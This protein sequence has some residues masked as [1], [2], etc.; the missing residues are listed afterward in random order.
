VQDNPQ[1]WRVGIAGTVQTMTD[2]GAGL[3]DVLRFGEGAAEGGWKGYGKD[4]LRLLMLLGP[5]GRIAG[6]ANRFL[7]PLI[8]AGNLRLAVQ[9][10]GVTGPCTFQAVNNALSIAKGKNLFVTVQD[11]AGALGKT[12]S[13][14]KRVA[15]NPIEYDLAAWADELVPVIRQAGI[16]VKEVG[17]LRSVDEV[18]KVAKTEAGPVVFAIRTTVRMKASGGVTAI[19]EFLHSVIAMRSPTG[20]VRFADYGGK[21]YGS[22]PE[23]IAKWGTP[24]SE[25]KLFQSGSSATV[26]E[27]IRLTGELARKIGN[28]ATLVMEGLA[29]IE[30][31][32][33]GVE[34]A[35]P[36][37]AVA[38]NAPTLDD[39]AEP[40]VVK[41]SFDAYKARAKGRPVVRL[42]EI[43]IK[44]G[45]RRAPRSDW[46]TGV[47]YRL[48]ALGFGAGPVDGIMGPRTRKAVMDFQ[49]AYP[50]LAVD[51]I[52]GGHTQARLCEVCGY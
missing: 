23:L 12:L 50:P 44:A 20:A 40:E 30:T 3:V 28:G 16:R 4:A 49:R 1:W 33:N 19:E 25:I 15:S 8:K 17:G 22:L 9:V 31:S 43:V 14:L 26:I 24:V 13:Q 34:M 6:A 5:A 32:E 39:P 7:T 46:L 35:V 27:G 48:N 41:G 45:S 29:A 51:G 47:Q 36:A 10:E 2:L 37:A 52:P 18:V 38:S 42:P 21:Y 11:M